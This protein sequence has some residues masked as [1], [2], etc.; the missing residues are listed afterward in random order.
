MNQRE[1]TF[2]DFMAMN[3]LEPKK[4]MSPQLREAQFILRRIIANKP[5]TRCILMKLQNIREESLKAIREEMKEH[6]RSATGGTG[7]KIVTYPNC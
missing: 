2:T 1:E 5:T 4:E 3:I 7:N 6:L